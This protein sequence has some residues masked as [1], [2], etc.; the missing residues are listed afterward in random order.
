MNM[1]IFIFWG[2]EDIDKSDVSMWDTNYIG[3]V[4]WDKK[5]IFESMES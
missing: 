4:V 2:V 5:F 3:E 1:D